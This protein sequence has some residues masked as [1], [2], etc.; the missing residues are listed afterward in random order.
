MEGWD[1]NAAL[2]VAKVAVSRVE[3]GRQLDLRAVVFDRRRRVSGAVCRRGGVLLRT[4]VR[5][6]LW[7]SWALYGRADGGLRVAV[8][9]VWR[10]T[11]DGVGGRSR[12]GHGGVNI[13][14]VHFL[15]DWRPKAGTR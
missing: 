13:E 10:D 2:V 11:V 7:D 6:P 15:P 9:S 4:G 3:N 12:G 8:W 5:V 14:G 1:R